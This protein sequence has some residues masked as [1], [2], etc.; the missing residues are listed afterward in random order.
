MSESPDESDSFP[1]RR[2]RKKGCRLEGHNLSSGGV[3]G[4][5]R[6][7]STK[8]KLDSQ[9]D[10]ISVESDSEGSQ[11]ADGE[12]EDLEEIDCEES[13]FVSDL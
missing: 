2:G 6:W 4:R 13:N 9:T 7:E 8:W 11:S 1:K 10:D 3:G 5:L 12:E